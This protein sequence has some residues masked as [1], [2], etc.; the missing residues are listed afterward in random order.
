[1]KDNNIPLLLKPLNDEDSQSQEE[2]NE[3]PYYNTG[4]APTNQ[5][6]TDNGQ[7]QNQIPV[8]NPPPYYDPNNNIQPQYPNQNNMQAPIYNP[9]IIINLQLIILI[10]T[11]LHIIIQIIINLNIILLK[12]LLNKLTKLIQDL[13]LIIHH[14]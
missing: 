4:S 11:N 9:N 12:A 10:T 7:A 2:I 5:N 1:M 14:Q 8:N 6:T 13:I 3:Q